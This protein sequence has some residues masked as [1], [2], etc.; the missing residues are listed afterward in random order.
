MFCGILCGPVMA[1]SQGCLSKEVQL[2][3]EKEKKKKKV[4]DI[5]S[6]AAKLFKQ[7]YLVVL[8]YFLGYNGLIL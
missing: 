7:D 4:R 8:N 6:P 3:F 1:D 2:T 5:W